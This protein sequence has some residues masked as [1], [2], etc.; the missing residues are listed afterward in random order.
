MNHFLQQVGGIDL[1]FSGAKFTWQNNQDGNLFIRERLDRVMSCNKWVEI[2][3]KAIVK[4]LL[5]DFSDHAP[6]LI[7]YEES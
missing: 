5:M 7:N 1:G 4:H 6:I 2:Y 3:P